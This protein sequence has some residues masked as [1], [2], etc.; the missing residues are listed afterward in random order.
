MTAV[1]TAREQFEQA[2]EQARTSIDRARAKF[3]KSIKD[4]RVKDGVRQDTIAKTLDLTREQIR[5][6]ER[7]YEDWVE[8]HGNL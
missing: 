4:A 8:R 1:V 7:Y 5:R 2:Q 3:G 6:Y